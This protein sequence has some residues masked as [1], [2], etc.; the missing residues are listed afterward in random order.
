MGGDVP[1][2]VIKA[3]TTG[4][5]ARRYRQ[6]LFYLETGRKS[7][8]RRRPKRLCMRYRCPTTDR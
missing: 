2:S 6:L 1:A 4:G 5:V 3:M 7:G 8:E